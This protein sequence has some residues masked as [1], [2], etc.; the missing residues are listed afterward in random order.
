MKREQMLENAPDR[1]WSHLRV[2]DALVIPMLYGN[3]YDG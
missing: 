3:Q 1:R 2:L